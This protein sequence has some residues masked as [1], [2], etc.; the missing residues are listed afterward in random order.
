MNCYDWFNFLVVMLH[1]AAEE[2]GLERPT[3]SY[4]KRKLLPQ[5][6]DEAPKPVLPVHNAADRPPCGRDK[7][8]TQAEHQPVPP[9]GKGRDMIARGHTYDLRQD[10]DNGAGQARSIYRSRGRART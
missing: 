1:M 5:F 6:D 7:T 2:Y 9:R 3:K 10:L 8:A 4:P